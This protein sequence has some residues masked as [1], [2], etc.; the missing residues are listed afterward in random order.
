MAR[1]R[2]RAHWRLA[3]TLLAFVAGLAAINIWWMSAR[4]AGGG[5]DIDEAGYLC[6]AMHNFE[7]WHSGG[8]SSLVSS[9]A[10]EQV[11]PPLVPFVSS[12]ASIV[13]GHPTILGSFVAQDLSLAVCVLAAFGIARALAGS[14]AGIVAVVAVAGAPVVIDYSRSYSFALPA[15]AMFTVAIW[16][17]MR[18]L[19]HTKLLWSGLWGASLGAMTICRTMTIAFVAGFLAV[20]LLQTASVADRRRALLGLVLGI[21]AGLVVAGPWWWSEGSSAWHYLT[22]AGY[23]A[24]SSLYGPPRSLLSLHSWSQFV[25]VNVESYIGL[26]L[27]LVLIV[28]ALSILWMALRRIRTKEHPLSGVLTS[29]WLGP[30]V[31]IAAAAIALFSSRNQGSAFIAPLVPAMCALAVAAAFLS[32][33]TARRRLI[34]V[35]LVLIAAVPTYVMKTVYGGNADN[36]PRLSLDV[37]GWGSTTVYDSRGTYD[38]YVTADAP[39]SGVRRSSWVKANYETLN[40]IG[41]LEKGDRSGSVV[42][43]GFNARLLNVN[44]LNLYAYVRGEAPLDP[45]LLSS[46]PA[47]SAIDYEHQLQLDA[48]RSAEIA[49]LTCD[50][51][52]MFPPEMNCRSERV[53]ATDDG[54][55]EARTLALPDGSEL[56]FWV[57]R[58]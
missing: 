18:S 32:L 26:P 12:L 5:F 48:G 35:A 42:T 40:V 27:A 39:Q 3:T 2:R 51:S 9:I 30:V 15:A 49:L 34:V 19:C 8:V 16:S 43:L 6:I 25:Y 37:P 47:Q 10:H 45:V 31:V 58:G 23:G 13:L 41:S 44:T 54:L 56:Q 29:S 53:A 55:R 36:P 28:G 11:Q 20:A 52:N 57:T 22:N 33:R 46:A 4:R 7:A 1:H 17:Q 14:T 21:A 50:A 38:E 24:Q